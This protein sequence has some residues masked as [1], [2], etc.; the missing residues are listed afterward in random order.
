[1]FY[2]D[3]STGYLIPVLSSAASLS[4]VN[5]ISD[6]RVAGFT[7]EARG[8]CMQATQVVNVS[9]SATGTSSQPPTQPTSAEGASRE[10]K[11]ETPLIKPQRFDGSQS[12]ETFLLQFEQLAEYMQWGEK[13][14]CYH[15]CASLEGP[16]GQVLWELPRTGASMADVKKLLQTKFGTQLQAEIFR[17]KLKVHRRKTGES[18]QDL[19]RDMGLDKIPTKLKQARD[20]DCKLDMA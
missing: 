14:R 7:T 2:Q 4:S 12:L 11:P 3:P 13:A 9:Q 10:G 8:T 16:A 17:A 20:M 1:M 19:Y 5:S 18:I 15:L 6:S